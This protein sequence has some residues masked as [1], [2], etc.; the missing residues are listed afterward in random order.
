MERHLPPL[1]EELERRAAGDDLWIVDDTGE[2]VLKTWISEHFPTVQVVV[3]EQNEGYARAL[4]HG[5]QQARGEL[6]FA[7]H[8]DVCVRPGFLDPL[9]EALEDPEVFAVSPRILVGSQERPESHNAVRYEDGRLRVIPR[10]PSGVPPAPRPIP[11]ATG[12]AMLVRREEFL[13]GGGFDPLYFPF[14]F[15]D[16]DLGLSAWRQGRRVLEIPDAVVEHE[17]RGTVDSSVPEELVQAAIEKNRLLLFWK[18]L[19]TRRDAQDHVASLWRDAVDAAMAG[20][21][22]ELIWLTLALQELPRVGRSRVGVG[23][24]ERSLEETLR[25]SDPVSC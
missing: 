17:A 23:K 11:F 10:D 1:L 9:V 3:H 5:A 7:T 24:A 13:K 22:E 21:R 25:V 4:L 12:A 2:G 8:P 16:V 19:D 6:L 15:E 20:R 18:Y 14:Y